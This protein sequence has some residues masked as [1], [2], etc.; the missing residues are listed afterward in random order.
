MALGVQGRRA[1]DDDE[2]RDDIGEQTAENHIPPRC[3]VLA[4][5]DPLLDDRRL[6]IKLHPR[7][8]RGADQPDDHVQVTVV[9]DARGLVAHQAVVEERRAR[10]GLQP[11]QNVLPTAIQIA[12]GCSELCP[13]GQGVGDAGR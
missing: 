6:Q 1:R 8:D 7:R 5:R 3:P 11:S 13:G 10:R 9:P 4:R 2:P 12:L